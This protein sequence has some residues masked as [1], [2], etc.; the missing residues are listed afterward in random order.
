MIERLILT[1]VGLFLLGVCL[2]MSLRLLYGARGPAPDDGVYFLLRIIGWGLVVIPAFVLVVAGANWLSFVLIAAIIEAVVQLTLARREAQRQAVWRLVAGA[3]SGGRSLANVLKIHQA[4]FSGIVGRWQRRLVADLERGMQWRQAIWRN[5]RAFPREAPTFA[6]MAAI[7]GKPDEVVADLDEVRDPAYHQLQ[8]ETS[9]RFMYL[10]NV[11]AVMLGVVTFVMIKIIPS[12]QSIFEDFDLQLPAITT[13]VILASDYFSR[14]LGGPILA[15]L[16]L[17]ALAGLVIAILYLCDIP[18][19]RRLTDRV[20][21]SRHRAEVMRLLAAGFEQGKPVDQS[22]AHLV[23]GWAPYPS[24]LVRRRLSRAADRIV[25]GDEWQESLANASL[26]SSTDTTVLRSA[27]AVGNLPWALRMLA[28][29]KMRLATFR[30]AITQQIVFVLL[31]LLLGFLVFLFAVAM[32][33]PL[34]YMVSNLAG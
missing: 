31:V 32:M 24:K 22:L 29:R 27:Q 6:S 4:R 26:I 18:V 13:S 12:F 10:M 25:A 23:I 2:R 3:I 1:S 9:L 11:C 28:S 20:L 34:S 7:G 17:A 33:V 19:L 5:R 8:Q 30:W 14:I 16:L 15:L 21:F